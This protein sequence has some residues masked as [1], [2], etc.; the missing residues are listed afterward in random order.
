MRFGCIIGYIIFKNYSY[1]LSIQIKMIE[2]KKIILIVNS[3][4]LLSLLM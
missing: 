3:I 4:Y 2:N 1:T